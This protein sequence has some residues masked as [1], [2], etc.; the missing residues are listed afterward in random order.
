MSV[1]NILTFIITCLL[2]LA[3]LV[4]CFPPEGIALGKWQL[5]FPDLTSVL[6]RYDTVRVTDEPLVLSPE[7]QLA[8]MAHQL[9]MEKLSALAD[10]LDFYEDLLSQA[11]ASIQFPDNDPRMLDG[12][13]QAM[14]QAQDR[15]QVVRVLHYGDSQI[16]QDRI[17]ASLRGNWQARFGGMG[18][19]L[20]PAVQNIPTPYIGQE[21]SGSMQRFMA[22]GSADFR[23]EHRQYGPMALMVRVQDSARVLLTA[24]H[25]RKPPFRTQLRQIRV[26][27]AN[28]TPGFQAVLQVNGQVYAQSLPD[29]TE[30]L[31]VLAWRLDRPVSTVD[32]SFWGSADIQGIALDDVSGVA[33]DNIPMRGC[34]G[35]IFSSIDKASLRQAFDWLQPRLIIL[36]YGGNRMPVI[37]TQE[38]IDLYMKRLAAQ[39]R[40]LRSLAPQA[41]FLFVGP[42]DMACRINGS[43]QTYPLLEPL[44]EALHTMCME[45]GV[46]FWDMYRVMG[47]RGSMAEWASAQPALAA[48][49][50]V[51]FTTR[52]ADRI[53]SLLNRSFDL[54]YDYYCFRREHLNDSVMLRL[55]EWE[56]ARP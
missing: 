45:N 48:T 47:G 49:D 13:F 9:E 43:L 50:Y 12:F 21:Y 54:C 35:T 24:R 34:S 37:H 46:A 19:G 44:I 53:A 55:R 7:E 38:D 20:V 51:H 26:L 52:G 32:L 33:V 5:R 22:Y 42:A 29:S 2:L 39:I 1:R 56:E 25:L 10:T 8:L 28:H 31:Q 18:C 11:Q 40:Y 16:E 41:A 23:V 27:V 36:E 6:A 30:A 17:T 15:G 4:L 3:L 14:E